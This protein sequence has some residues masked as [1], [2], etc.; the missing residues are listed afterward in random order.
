MISILIF[1]SGLIFVVGTPCLESEG[2]AVLGEKVIKA[3]S[4]MTQVNA[5]RECK[6][7]CGELLQPNS[8]NYLIL[9]ELML[10]T[11]S[12]VNSLELNYIY[13]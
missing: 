2:W 13:V 5:V 4:P 3:F 1:V 7:E 12:E 8:S 10:Q 11:V 9:Q 6:K